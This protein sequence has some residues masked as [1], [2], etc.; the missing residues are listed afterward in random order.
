MF[1]VVMLTGKREAINGF[2]FLGLP[3]LLTNVEYCTYFNDTSAWL[4]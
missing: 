3:Y 1:Y 2:N 4:C